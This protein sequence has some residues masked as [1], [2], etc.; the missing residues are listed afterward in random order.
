[1][2]SLISCLY[3]HSLKRKN[4]KSL[5]VLTKSKKFITLMKPTNSYKP[6]I[7][8]DTYLN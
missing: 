3:L 2:R 1:M 5:T 4:T 8:Y 7:Q 6:K